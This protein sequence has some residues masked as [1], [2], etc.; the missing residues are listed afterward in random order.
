MWYNNAAGNLIL[1][2]SE[3]FTGHLRLHD[4]ALHT[5]LGTNHAALSHL[6]SRVL[7]VGH[8][9]LLNDPASATGTRAIV[10]PNGGVQA[11]IVIQRGHWGDVP[12]GTNLWA[13]VPHPNIHIHNI[14]ITGTRQAPSRRNELADLIAYA[15]NLL[16]TTLS[17]ESGESI[18]PTQ[19]WATQTARN[20][21]QSAINA[22]R[23]VLNTN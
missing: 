8:A 10:V 15:Q 14:V 3:A 16:D 12:L 4:S 20:N 1:P 7:P 6:P 9:A 23:Q 5:I 11:K 13:D 17:A 2:H 21:F 18:S 22:A 19:Y